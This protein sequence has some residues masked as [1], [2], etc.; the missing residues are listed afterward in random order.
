MGLWMSAEAKLDSQPLVIIDPTVKQPTAKKISSV[1]DINCL[2]DAFKKKGK[3]SLLWSHHMYF[4]PSL[5]GNLKKNGYHVLTWLKVLARLQLSRPRN[6]KNWNVI[7]TAIS[8]I[9]H[10]NSTSVAALMTWLVTYSIQHQNTLA[11]TLTCHSDGG[12]RGSHCKEV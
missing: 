2:R 9:C 6:Y 3:K 4:N 1:S 11:F 12:S 10:L 5:W 8:E 7:I